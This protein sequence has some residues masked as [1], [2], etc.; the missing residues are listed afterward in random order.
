[1]NRFNSYQKGDL[2]D[3]ENTRE[4]DTIKCPYC[5]KK[6]TRGYITGCRPT[7]FSE[8]ES[9]FKQYFPTNGD[10]VLDGYYKRV[11]GYNCKHCK[12]IIFDYK[13]TERNN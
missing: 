12:I 9:L 6:M 10:I 13:L 1:M 11:K 5:G 3:F 4:H 2:W 7:Y 8:A